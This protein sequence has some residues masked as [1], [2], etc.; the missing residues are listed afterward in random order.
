MSARGRYRFA[1]SV[2][3]T[4][5][6]LVAGLLAYL[7]SMGSLVTL[8][9]SRAL[10]DT[11]PS[12][13]ESA[14]TPG[15]RERYALHVRIVELLHS[16][17][18]NE[19]AKFGVLDRARAI[20]EEVDAEHS[21]DPRLRFDLGEVYYALDLN[22]EAIRVLAPATREHD[23]HPAAIRAIG[24]LAYAYAKLDRSREERDTYTRYLD[25]LVE[26]HMRASALMNR[27]EADMRLGDLASA[28]R[29][30]DD[31]LLEIRPFAGQEAYETTALANWGLA[32]ALDRA[33][34]T[35]RAKRE[36]TQAASLDPK[37]VIIGDQ[38][39]V[40][41]VPEY[42]RLA[43]LAL[44]SK[45]LAEST[46]DPREALLYRQG[47]ALYWKTYVARATT[48]ERW[49]AH[50]KARLAEA[51]KSLAAAEKVAKKAPVRTPDDPEKV[52]SF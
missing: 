34:E 47:Q 27:A 9:E 18:R 50:A 8:A 14:R 52:F 39:N 19:L 3:V 31:A 25:K 33:G 26:P 51:E 48:N 2:P 38:Q 32:L 23:D 29:G 15:A 7:V 44:G 42:E 21:P 41:F 10:A 5:R 28:I 43:Y 35:G 20:L 40:F 11:P 46:S 17:I 36:A 1:R 16:S 37:L 13:W 49:L 45:A 30:Y 4:A 6:A 24:T 22:E 12:M